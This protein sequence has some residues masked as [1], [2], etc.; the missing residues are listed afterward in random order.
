MQERKDFGDALVKAARAPIQA[1][2]ARLGEG[3]IGEGIAALSKADLLAGL[4]QGIENAAAVFKLRNVDVEALLPWDAL[5]PTLDRLEAAQIAALRAVQQHMATVGGP[6]SG[7]TRGAPFDARKQTG[8]E[9]LFKVAKRFAADPR[10]CGPIELFGTEVSGW[11]TLVS[12][13]GDRLESSP[14]HTRY[15][16]RKILVRS[17]LVIVILGSF[18]VAGRSAYKTKQIEHARARV[19]AALRAEDPCAV[20][21]LAPEDITL[22]TP[23]QVT[24]EKSRLEAC[25]SGRAR[26]RYVAACETLAKNFD[27]GKLSAD[28]LAVAKEAAP[29]LE[30]AQK[31]EL[32]VE[33]LLATPKDMPCQDSPSKDRFF[34]TYAAAAAD[35]KKVWTEATRVSDDLRDALRGKDVSTKP[36]RDELTR[37]AEPAAAKA[38]LSGKPEDMELGQKLCDFAASFGI[39]RGKKCT[40]LAA[41]LAKKR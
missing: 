9:A 34:G 7:P 32:G 11:E 25:A 5:L 12:Q 17:A 30:R 22:A 18:S 40:G 20:E 4:R 13:C 23:E 16:R 2:N 15:A 1:A 36:Y 21:K 8:A 19:D 28:D 29:R 41:V 31:R 3:A 14:L 37:R 33:D 6:L 10:V 26:A 38:I 24:G 35:S 39:E 27:A